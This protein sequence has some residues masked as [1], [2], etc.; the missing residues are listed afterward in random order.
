MRIGVKGILLAILLFLGSCSQEVAKEKSKEE[1][2]REFVALLGLEQQLAENYDRCIALTKTLPLES[3]LSDHPDKFYG[4]RPNSELWPKALAAYEAYHLAACSKPSK[5]ES[6]HLVE[7]FFS[8]R[9]SG[10]QL[11]SAVAFYST[12]VGQQI[13][14]TAVLATSE[15]GKKM[16]EAGTRQIPIASAEFERKLE[17]IAN[18]QTK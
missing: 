9:L 7:S 18:T 11:K 16:V 2:A 5:E 10:S 13:A 4:I 14:I 15:L 3:F 6:L 1:L 8:T 17:H 12:D